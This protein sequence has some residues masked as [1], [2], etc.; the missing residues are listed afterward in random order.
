MTV[1]R[2]AAALIEDSAGRL[3]LV[4]KTGT[5]FFM[6]AGGKI[7]LGETPA[8]A[9]VRELDEEIG[10]TIAEDALRP[11][12]RFSAAAANEPGHQVDATVFHL[13]VDHDPVPAAEI[14]EAIWVDV[15]S[16]EAM[17]IAPLLREHI[18]P[19]WRDEAGR[20]V[21]ICDGSR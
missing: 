4:R 20:G 16:V 13:C 7:E 15:D 3:L 12:G 19:C 6:Q 8:A 14:A 5:R 9:L 18:L 11:V 21:T 1:I 17:P 10:L 2:I